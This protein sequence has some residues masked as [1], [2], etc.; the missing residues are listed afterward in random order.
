M[1]SIV[2]IEQFASKY[3]LQLRAVKLWNIP[4]HIFNIWD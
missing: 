4:I 3:K 2:H 1:L